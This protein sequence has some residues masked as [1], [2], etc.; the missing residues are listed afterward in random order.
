MI[1]ADIVGT[2]VGISHLTAVPLERNLGLGPR[3]DLNHWEGLW[4]SGTSRDTEDQPNPS[5]TEGVV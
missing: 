5:Q 2:R 4:R 3:H 1:S